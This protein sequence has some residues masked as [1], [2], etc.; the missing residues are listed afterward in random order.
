MTFDPQPDDIVVSLTNRAPF[1]RSKAYCVAGV[2]RFVER[3]LTFVELP[4]FYGE[5]AA[6]F[7]AATPEETADYLLSI[8]GRQD[9]EALF[10]RR[11][12]RTTPEPDTCSWVNPPASGAPDSNP[13]TRFGMAKPALSLI[14]GTARVLLAAAFAD[15]CKKYGPANWR[16]DPVSAS[17]YLN[18][19]ERHV[20]SW[21]DGEENAADSG[22][23]HLAHAAACLLI[24]LDAQANGTL[25]DDRPPAGR[26]ADLIRELTLPLKAA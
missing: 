7:R 26:T 2:T 24:L 14:P 8:A 22:V 5:S 10:D 20:T 17:T 21:Q 13:K 25:L 11:A 19:A 16:V 4:G 15:G 18:A 6:F 9:A 3:Q 23:H 1:V 12:A